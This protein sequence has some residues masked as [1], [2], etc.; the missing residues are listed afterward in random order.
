VISGR[1]KVGWLFD[2]LVAGPA[3]AY[4]AL[5]KPMLG[6]LALVG[7]AVLPAALL[8]P[9]L[10]ALG[11]VPLSAV[12]AKSGMAYTLSLAGVVLLTVGAVLAGRV[13]P[14]AGGQRT[15][16]GWPALCV[17]ALILLLVVSATT[18]QPGAPALSEVRSE[19]TGVVAGLVLVVAAS[20]VP[21]CPAALARTLVLTGV[22]VAGY[23][24]LEGSY[25]S[26]RL[27]GVGLG[28]NYLGAL[29]ALPAAA[30][31]GL[32]R[33]GNGLVWFVPG[34]VCMAAVVQTHSRGGLL[35]AAAGVGIALLGERP[36]R[37]QLLGAATAAVVGAALA[38][39]VDPLKDVA[40]GDRTSTELSTNSAARADAIRLGIDVAVEHPLRGIGYGAF[41]DF[42]A[43]HPTLGIFMNTHNDYVRLAAESGVASLLLFVA[44]LVAGLTAK[45]RGGLTP[46]RAAVTAGAV[47]LVFTNSMSNL[48]VS[49]GLW[50]C[51]GCMLAC[52]ARPPSQTRLGPPEPIDSAMEEKIRA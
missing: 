7:V 13:G 24:L 1:W 33:R 5:R 25:T 52:R 27:G 26:G 28:T 2:A 6:G 3:V 37:V 21:L 18:G 48:V 49:G 32:A 30:A 42:A 15:R 47:N 11:L 9:D 19:L 35:A 34:T 4:L 17:G 39:A 51:L 36:L 31:V 46:L 14:Y 16:L 10:L 45:G 38:T 8:R 20:A 41:S 44:V 29:L 12:G 23:A 22:A 40:L 43:G 50:I